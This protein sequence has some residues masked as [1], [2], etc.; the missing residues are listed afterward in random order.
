MLSITSCCIVNM[1]EIYQVI[2]VCW[3]G[4]TSSSLYSP[5]FNA[6]FSHTETCTLFQLHSKSPWGVNSPSWV[7]E[8]AAGEQK[9][10]WPSTPAA[11]AEGPGEIQEAA[12]DRAAETHRAAERAEEEAGGCRD[13]LA[14]LFHIPSQMKN[15]PVESRLWKARRLC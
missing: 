9:P 6:I 2:F 8:A 10:F 1:A 14:L 4:T 13:W 15:M 3:H 11:A 5:C 7:S 12:A